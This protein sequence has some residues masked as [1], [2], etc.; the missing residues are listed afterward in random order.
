MR[1]YDATG[2]HLRTVGRAGEGPGEFNDIAGVVLARDTLFAYDSDLRRVSLWSPMG[3]YLALEVVPE[4]PRMMGG[5]ASL[6]A[7]AA[8]GRYVFFK[9]GIGIPRRDPFELFW[10]TKPNL[11]VTRDGTRADTLGESG[12]HWLTG[13]QQIFPPPYGRSSSMAAEPTRI[14]VTHGER[15]EIEVWG[16][17]TGTLERIIRVDREP[18][19][20]DP[21]E[22]SRLVHERSERDLRAQLGAEPT[23]EARAGRRRLLEHLEPFDSKPA[24][25]GILIGAAGEILARPWSEDSNPA[26]DVF[27]ADGR[28]VASVAIPASFSVRQ[29]GRDFLLAAYRD[30][31]GVEYVASIPLQ[32]E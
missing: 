18:P 19:T 9:E 14:V 26:W 21:S 24:Y 32:R 11:V 29:V 20:L 12:F 23:A 27:D 16:I 15:Y 5:A 31:M 17:R 2:R 6:A 28:L 3:Q 10:Y 7:I 30:S 4:L 8:D 25:T 1:F 22:F 13:D